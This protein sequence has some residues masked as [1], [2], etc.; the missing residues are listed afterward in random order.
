VGKRAVASASEEFPPK[1]LET[2][3]QPEAGRIG[4]VGHLVAGAAFL[5][6]LAPMLYVAWY[7]PDWL[8]ISNDEYASDVFGGAMV[9]AP[10]PALLAWGYFTHAF[11]RR[12]LAKETAR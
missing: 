12:N 1:D 4:M 11:R 8:G 5:L 3:V 9:F 10:L 2:Q 6:L 7:L